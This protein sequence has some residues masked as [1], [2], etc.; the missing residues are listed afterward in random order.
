MMTRITLRQGFSS[1][2]VLL[3]AACHQPAPAQGFL[4]AQQIFNAIGGQFSMGLPR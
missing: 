2:A 4:T 1:A 3:L